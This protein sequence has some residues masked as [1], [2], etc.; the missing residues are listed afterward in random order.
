MTIGM[1]EL[2]AKIAQVMR[3]NVADYVHIIRAVFYADIK[4]LLI[5]CFILITKFHIAHMVFVYSHLY[6]GTPMFSINAF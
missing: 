6:T 1:P 3:S 4:C 5:N 2:C